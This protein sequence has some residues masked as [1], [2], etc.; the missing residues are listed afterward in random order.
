MTALA[1]HG[2][3]GW[4]YTIDETRVKE[5]AREGVIMFQY[6]ATDALYRYFA[7]RPAEL[8]PPADLIPAENIE[9]P[10]RPASNA[11]PGLLAE[12]YENMAA[13]VRWQSD[14][15]AWRQGVEQWREGTEDRLESIEELT[16]LVPEILDRLGPATLTPAHQATVR[17]SVKRL[18]DLTGASFGSIYADLGAAFHVPRYQELPESEWARV[19]EWLQTRI[20]AAEKRQQKH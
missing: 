14:I 12:Y 20:H 4:L 18:A 7:E 17:A 10:T 15:A 16:R 19:A 9:K 11:A 5:E 8:A 6:E 1:L 2:L 13:W 3:P